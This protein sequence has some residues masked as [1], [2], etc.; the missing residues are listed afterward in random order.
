[1]SAAVTLA[2]LMACWTGPRQRSTRSA[3]SCSNVERMSVVTRCLGPVAS[4][5]MKGRLTCV[6]VTDE[7]STLAFSAASNRRCSAWGSCA[8]VDAVVALELV[9]EAVDDAPVEVVAAEVG[10]ARG[11]PHLDHAVA[12]VEDADVEGA[13]AEVEHQHGLVR[14]SCPSRRPARPRSAR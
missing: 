14:A 9:G 8:Q 12:H 10:V 2:S 11:G 7:S 1:M 3:V 13:A 6:W 4:A 5:V